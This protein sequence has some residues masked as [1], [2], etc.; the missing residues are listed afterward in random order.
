MT[1]KLH[2]AKLKSI[3]FVEVSRFVYDQAR[4][5]DAVQYYMK[6][7]QITIDHQRILVI[8]V[9]QREELLSGRTLP[10]IRI[11][12]TKHD[13]ISQRWIDG[14]YKWR[15]GRLE[16]LVDYVQ[17]YRYP[18]I[19]CG[20]LAS[21]RVLRRF[22]SYLGNTERKM[23]D[24]INEAQYRIRQKRLQKKHQVIKDRIDL[25]MQQIKRMPMGFQKWVDEE[26]LYD[27]RYIYYRYERKPIMDGY[28]TCCHSDVKVEKPKHRTVGFCPNCGKKVTYLAEGKARRVRDFCNTAYFQKT[29]RGFIVRYFHVSKYYNEDY[30]NPKL[31][32]FEYRRDFVEGVS[33]DLYV[34]DE[35]KQTGEYR[36]CETDFTMDYSDTIVY[37]RNLDKVLRNTSFQFSALKEYLQMIGNK[38]ITVYW[39]LCAYTT[40]P[41]LE[42]FVKN[43][44][45]RLVDEMV[46]GYSYNISDLLDR[47]ATT[48]KQLFGVPKDCVQ[49]ICRM[50]MNA[51]Y[52]RVYL[53]LV[54]KGIRISDQEFAD[55]FKKYSGRYTEVLEL[56]NQTTLGKIER[57]C[58]QI[59]TR[60]PDLRGVFSIWWDYLRFAKELGYDMKKDIIFFPR[61]LKE[62]HDQAHEEL[63]EKKKKEIMEQLKKDNVLYEKIVEGYIHT[64][65]WK[66]ENYSVIVPEDL[67]SIK[68]EGSALN[69]C[70]GTYTNKVAEQKS[71]ILFVRKNKRSE[72][73]YFTMEVKDGK[74]IQC[75]GVGNCDM[76]EDLKIF[77][78]RYEKNILMPLKMKMAV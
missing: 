30:R 66:D 21:E 36:W 16:T 75:R 22:F 71:V 70:V 63:Q 46:R 44:L 28:C 53:P 40:K 73:P 10:Q 67:F 41:Y 58:N 55:F 23:D 64:Y 54:K 51:S 56:L 59:Q 27:S 3:P 74:I 72:R 5:I 60:Y 43:G 12:M 69:H 77:V 18:N 17:G 20:D 47:Q 38:G 57:Y 2:K 9:Y 76:P 39:Y 61:N 11:F 8:N 45:R 42:L 50:D 4:R 48:L 49:Q 1:K 34:Y 19:I 65:T 52:L 78:H 37:M 35:F 29:L 32:L 6:A 31:K 33:I 15:T 24:L 25:R 68:E 13:Y 26:A 14:E 62:A 7:K